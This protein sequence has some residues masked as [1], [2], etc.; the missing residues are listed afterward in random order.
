ME[1]KAWT[2]PMYLT[3]LIQSLDKKNAIECGDGG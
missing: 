3:V 1:R 2:E